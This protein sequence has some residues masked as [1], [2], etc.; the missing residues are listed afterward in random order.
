M[1]CPNR[2]EKRLGKVSRRY[3]RKNVTSIT[4]WP[5]KARRHLFLTTSR[6]GYHLT[7]SQDNIFYYETCSYHHNIISSYHQVIISSYHHIVILSCYQSV[8]LSYHHIIVSSCHHTV[9][10]YLSNQRCPKMMTAT[11]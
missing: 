8:I 10:L 11:F 3:E 9:I 6:C 4:K 1:E 7:P 2:S 5:S